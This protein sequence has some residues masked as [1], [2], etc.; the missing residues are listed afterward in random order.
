MRKRGVGLLGRGGPVIMC[1]VAYS[2]LIKSLGHA[3]IILCK[4]SDDV[5]EQGRPWW[6]L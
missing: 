3:D 5:V 6:P 2:G 4:T 1:P